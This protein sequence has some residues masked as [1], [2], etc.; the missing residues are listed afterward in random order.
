MELK[1]NPFKAYDIRG[2]IGE[3][4]TEEIV[5]RI[6]QAF[7]S[8][9]NP[10]RVVIGFD[11]RATSPVFA[12]ALTRGLRRMGVD[13]QALGQCGT[14]EVYFA[15]DHLGAGGGLMV[16]ASHN[17]IE[18][19]GIKM[20]L[21]CAKPITRETGLDQIEKLVLSGQV[22]S[23]SPTKGAT[24][25][26][27]IRAAYL[28]R[29][30]SFVDAPKMTGL[31]VLANSGNGAAG[32]VAKAL[33]ATLM[34]QG[35]GIELI[36]RFADPD[37]AFPNG[38]PNPL[39]PENHAATAQAV[40]DASADFGVAWDGDFD[41]CF[42]FD[43]TG[44]FV[45]GAYVV[46]LLAKAFLRRN[47]GEKIVY[48]PRVVFNTRDIVSA[49]GG[50]AVSARTGHA[51]MKQAMR[52]AGAIYGG[53]MSAH[54][55]FRDFMYCD[56][57]MIPFVLV[58][59]LVASSGRSLADLVHE[60]VEGFPVSGEINFQV[61]DADEAIAKVIADYA[62]QAI[63][64]DDSDGVALE[65]PTWRFNLRKSNTEPLVRL[66]I[67]AKGN[68]DLVARQRDRIAEMLRP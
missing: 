48:D 62:D 59:E 3:A 20:V 50:I 67:E 1:E 2:R 13:V 16:T 18:Y 36:H 43:H 34:A 26:V 10:G 6:G 35:A 56:S 61:E 42:F 22:F 29:V 15:T 38:I 30:L 44:A 19:N 4:L 7:A 57:G 41:R 49:Q 28:D 8:V 11:A 52:S 46:G 66:N 53:E 58:A 37:P 12:D 40:V 55:Y 14:E 45:D 21:G 47:P 27:D 51:F 9:A 68:A 63:D 60:M 5:E 31:R 65:F 54:H 39:L 33:G 24:E 17:P 32:P 64:R 23:P 25:A